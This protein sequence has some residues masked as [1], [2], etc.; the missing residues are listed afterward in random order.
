MLFFDFVRGK[1]N[2][3]MEE[4]IQLVFFLTPTETSALDNLYTSSLKNL[5]HEGSIV[6][7]FAIFDGYL[8]WP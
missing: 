7:W 3:G 2:G 4:T 1:T 8:S 5:R 6:F